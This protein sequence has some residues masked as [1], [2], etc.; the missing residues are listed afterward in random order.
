MARTKFTARFKPPPLGSGAAKHD[1]GKH[2]SEDDEFRLAEAEIDRVNQSIDADAG[3][4]LPHGFTLRP[5]TKR[6]NHS[7]FRALALFTPPNICDPSHLELRHVVVNRL[8]Y[9][10]RHEAF[11]MFMRGVRVQQQ[12]KQYRGKDCTALLTC[13]GVNMNMVP[14]L[15]SRKTR[16]LKILPRNL[17]TKILDLMRGETQWSYLKRM[18]GRSGDRG[19]YPELVEVGRLLNRHIVVLHHPVT[20]PSAAR[21]R[22]E[23]EGLAN[24][25]ENTHYLMRLDGGHFHAVEFCKN[26][27]MDIVASLLLP[28]GLSIYRVN[29]NTY[30][31]YRSLS[32][33]HYGDESKFMRIYIRVMGGQGDYDN[34]VAAGKVLKRHI[35]VYR[36]KDLNL[37][38]LTVTHIFLRDVDVAS[39]NTLYLL[40]VA[41][42]RYHALEQE[43]ELKVTG[44]KNP[45]N[46]METRS[47]SKKK[48]RLTS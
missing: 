19:D 46:T 45:K 20:H 2:E 35:I 33:L 18:Q 17:I 34:L 37:V 11:E 8:V 28:P 3:F 24:H 5:C 30:T 4:H 29:S 7:L 26:E 40:Q 10:W 22:F 13:M 16:G 31:V 1:P 25:E 9:Q 15:A 23:I 41:D 21:T 44:V 38:S 27:Q 14:V 42:G 39:D 36:H 6:D 47:M 32:Y 12:E 48:S 43:R